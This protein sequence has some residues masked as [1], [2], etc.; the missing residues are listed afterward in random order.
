[1]DNNMPPALTTAETCATA[2]QTVTVEAAHAAM[3]DHLTCPT[4]TCAVRRTARQAL[5][6]AGV[7][8]LADNAPSHQRRRGAAVAAPHD[9]NS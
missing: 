4:N 3:Q 1:M 7:Y 6:A 2:P 8:V 5:V 9:M